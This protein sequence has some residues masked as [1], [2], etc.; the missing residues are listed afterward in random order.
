[1]DMKNWLVKR[2][3]MVMKM[4]NFLKDQKHI[5]KQ[6]K[7]LKAEMNNHDKVLIDGLTDL[8]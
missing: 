6:V 2:K 8:E 3:D 4:L 7:L 1:M 5:S